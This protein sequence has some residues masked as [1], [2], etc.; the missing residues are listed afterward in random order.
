MVAENPI[1]PGYK[2]DFSPV[3]TLTPHRQHQLMSKAEEL[4]ATFLSEMLSYSGLSEMEGAF[5]GG[6]GEA[7]FASFLRQEQARLIVQNG[8]L[9]L[10]ELIFK[11]MTEAESEQP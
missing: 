8:G 2:M 9:G 3:A 1:Y 7:Q 5:G 6:Q 11:S 4:E 10:A